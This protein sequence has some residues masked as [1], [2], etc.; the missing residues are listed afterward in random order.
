LI[1]AFMPDPE[2]L[3]LD[4]PTSGLD[5]VLQDEVPTLLSERKNDGAT[6]WLTSHVMAEI[7]RVADRVG[8]INKGRLAK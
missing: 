7:D 2:L 8:L 1:L 6:I 3:V 5:P 4:E